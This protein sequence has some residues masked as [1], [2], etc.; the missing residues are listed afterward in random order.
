MEP[1]P[2]VGFQVVDKRRTQQA[3][4]A[5]PQRPIPSGS[6]AHSVLLGYCSEDAAR[7]LLESKGVPPDLVDELIQERERAQAHVLTLAPLDDASAARPLDDVK[8]L[9]EIDRVMRRP[10][11][12]GAYP[13]GSWTAELVE[14][15]KIIPLQPGLDVAYAE[16]VGGVDLDP[17]NLMPAVKICFAEMHPAESD[18]SADQ[19]QKAISVS[20]TNPSLEVVGLSYN[21]QGANG[22]VMVS[23][24]ISPSPHIATV[25][26]YAGRHFVSNGLHRIYRLLKAGFTHVPCVVREAQTLAQ[27]ARAG[28][29]FFPE[30]VLM[31]PRPPVVPDF[32]D[33]VLGVIVPFPAVRRVV[34][35]RPDEYFV[36]E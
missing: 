6:R 4:G 9:T 28:C 14:I 20:G 33:P 5:G 26:R 8:A 27:A 10:D 3:D 35:I 32:A 2:G 31:A 23:F 1:N 15:A 30:S 19:S 25:F 13:E 21:Q 17:R 29:A 18:I 16:N 22:P 12:Q 36:P 34:R 24:L 7:N 11:C